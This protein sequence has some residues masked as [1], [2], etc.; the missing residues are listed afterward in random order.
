VSEATL[1]CQLGSQS[2]GVCV[3]DVLNC[4]NIN[5]CFSWVAKSQMIS[6]GIVNKRRIRAANYRTRCSA[7]VGHCTGELNEIR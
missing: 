6:D 1:L 3:S 5:M 4:G 7:L 2:A